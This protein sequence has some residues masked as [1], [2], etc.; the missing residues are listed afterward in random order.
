[1]LDNSKKKSKVISIDGPSGSGKSTM[2]RQIAKKL[3]ILY[4]D[5]GAMFRALAYV[6]D[7]NKISVEDAKN[8]YEMSKQFLDKLKFEYAPTDSTSKILI[9][10]NDQDLT[11]KIREHH[12]STMASHYSQIPAIRN[13]LLKFQRDLAM[14]RFCVME[15]RDI[16]TV[17]FPDSFCKIFMV[18]DLPTRAKRRL[19]ELTAKGEKNLSLK[20][21]CHDLEKRDLAD[22][23][24]IHAPLIQANDA[25]LLDTSG[26]NQDEVLDKIIVEVKACL[27]KWNMN[28]P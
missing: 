22:T 10:I 9:R 11:E 27:K 3:N 17:V 23:S 26:L 16:G 28:I 25:F 15:G 21:V 7:K 13:F 24:R 18:A 8:Q 2:A 1:M 12:I 4:V 20:Q 14:E 6:F 5:T 19:L